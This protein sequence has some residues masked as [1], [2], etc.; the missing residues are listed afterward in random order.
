MTFRDSTP[1]T[2]KLNGKQVELPG[3]ITISQLLA[4][5][6]LKAQMVVVEI[7]GAIVARASFGDVFVRSGDEVEIVHFVGGGE[8]LP[9]EPEATIEIDLILGLEGNAFVNEQTFH[10]IGMAKM[11]AARKLAVAVDDTVRG[12]IEIGRARVEHPTNYARAAR[13]SE[14]S[15]DRTVSGDAAEWNAVDD[16]P[17]TA[18]P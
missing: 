16:G 1:V 8:E 5:K 14:R 6:D 2:F 7:N 18:T 3:E 9:G 10:H 17:D 13:V 4:G 12:Q 11:P 15:G